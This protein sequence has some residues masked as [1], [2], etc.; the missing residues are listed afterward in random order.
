MTNNLMIFTIFC[1]IICI[2]TITLSDA[3]AGDPLLYNNRKPTDYFVNHESQ[4]LEL[5][6]KLL[7]HHTVGVTGITGK[8]K[9]EMVRKYTS[10]HQNDYEIIASFDTQVDL[11]PQYINLAKDINSMICLKEGCSLSLS[12][13]DVKSD[14]MNFLFQKTKWLLIFDNVQLNQNYKIKNIIN[15]KHNSHIIITSQ[16][17]KFMSNIV[18]TPYLNNED[19]MILVK[20]IIPDISDTVV[21]QIVD[22]CQGYPY[23]INRV[24]TFISNYKHKTVYEVIAFIER[25]NNPVRSYTELLLQS[26]SPTSKELLLKI[27][28]LNNQGVSRNILNHIST[29]KNTLPEDIHELV[30]LGALEQI[31]QDINDQIFQLHDVLN[32]ELIRKFSKEL[33][34]KNVDYIVDAIIGMLPENDKTRGYVI[35]SEDKTMISNLEKILINSDY[36]SGDIHKSIELRT[37]VLDYYIDTRDPVNCS[38]L[39]DW[40]NQKQKILGK[41]NDKQKDMYA[42]NLTKIGYYEEFANS[43]YK[44]AINYYK[45]ALNIASTNQPITKLIANWQLASAQ[46]SLGDLDNARKSIEEAVIGQDPEVIKDNRIWYL[47]ARILLAQG[48]YKKALDLV[49]EGLKIYIKAGDKN[50][51]TSFYTQLFKVEILNYMGDYKEAYNIV[52]D[53]YLTSKEHLVNRKLLEDKILVQLARAELGLNM[54]DQTL[55]HSEL[56]IKHLIKEEGG[57]EFVVESINR[58]LANAYVVYGD[59]LTTNNKYHEAVKNYD[60]AEHIYYNRYRINTRNVDEVSYVLAQGAKASCYIKSKEW[61]DKFFNNL[62]RY[63]TN[64]HFRVQEV[65]DFCKN[66]Q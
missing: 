11:I 33:H 48:N 42:Y 53:L 65:K 34:Q 55:E 15:W 60:I 28:L 23:L 49:N 50:S 52:K 57:E 20:K 2:L 35:I 46:I 9:S 31:S 18:K 16:D 25:D 26:I 45:K 47:Q 22:K 7:K 24:A 6:N 5:R 44:K 61:Y 62:L 38:K 66:Y 59:V 29:N 19:A 21:Q 8:G 58:D 4:I 39:A 56:A 12:P 27:A 30:M 32:N 3:L 51:G 13:K 64:K 41:M 54:N 17:T 37:H 63:F 14:L 40:I 10:M 36:Y 1:Y 43:N